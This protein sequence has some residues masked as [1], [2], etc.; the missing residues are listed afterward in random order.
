MHCL[1][2]VAGSLLI[3]LVWHLAMVEV[4]LGF[5]LI[6]AAA[7]LLTSRLPLIPNKELLFANFAIMVIGQGEA[8]SALVAF[9]A[10]LSLAVHAVLIGLFGIEAFIN[11]KRT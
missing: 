5:W 11:R 3:A 10:A 4:A 6:L 7:R 8:L 9:T 2:L 1:R